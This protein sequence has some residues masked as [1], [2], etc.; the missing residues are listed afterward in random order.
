MRYP[1]RKP[2]PALDI[3][4]PIVDIGIPTNYC[5][6]NIENPADPCKYDTKECYTGIP[7]AI[8]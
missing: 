1:T 4:R 3:P 8:I 2:E 7:K 5:Q 6:G